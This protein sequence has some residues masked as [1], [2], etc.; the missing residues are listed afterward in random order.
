MKLHHQLQRKESDP[1]GIAFKM[2]REEEEEEEAKN[3]KNDVAF[4]FFAIDDGVSNRDVIHSSSKHKI[5][6]MRSAVVCTTR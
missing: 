2:G 6:P 1:G 4:R 5:K 3:L